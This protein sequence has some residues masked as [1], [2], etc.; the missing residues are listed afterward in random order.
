MSVT[1]PRKRLLQDS[2]N[3]NV[4]IEPSTK[5]NAIMS[6]YSSSKR[7][8]AQNLLNKRKFENEN[9]TKS[10]ETFERTSSV[11][12]PPAKRLQ[13][14]ERDNNKANEPSESAF[15][16]KTKKTS[17]TESAKSFSFKKGK[18]A[19]LKRH[20][21]FRSVER[22]PVLNQ[23]QIMKFDDISAD[24]TNGNLYDQVLLELPEPDIKE[25]PKSTSQPA[26]SST[27]VLTTASAI[28]TPT[29]QKKP[30]KKSSS[31]EMSSKAPTL[32]FLPQNSQKVVTTSAIPTTNV[33]TLLQSTAKIAS[34]TAVTT[35]SK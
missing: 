32:N 27:T 20:S 11:L 17:S 26:I 3:E 2:V 22:R 18:T 30:L 6:S 35:Q 24:R 12:S 21:T 9:V 4:S 10:N 7:L 28:S 8:K 1:N 34:S 23:T 19:R 31:L 13:V 29:N 33:T 15:P 14:E 5:R 25:T 16:N